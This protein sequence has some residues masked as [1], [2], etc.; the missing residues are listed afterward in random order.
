MLLRINKKLLPTKQVFAH[1][2]C[3]ICHPVTQAAEVTVTS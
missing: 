1:L 3:D 2:E